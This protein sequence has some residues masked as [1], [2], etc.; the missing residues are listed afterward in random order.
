MLGGALVLGGLAA[1]VRI[2]DRRKGAAGAASKSHANLLLNVESNGSGTAS[3]S[4]STNGGGKLGNRLSDHH[5]ELANRLADHHRGSGSDSNSTMA[6]VGG[7]GCGASGGVG[8]GGPA[9]G[10]A[11]ASGQQHQRHRRDDGDAAGSGHA[12]GFAPAKR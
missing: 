12:G 11:A 6:P 8:A 9:G 10:P 2:K 1:N 7:G 3:H 5:R 4:G